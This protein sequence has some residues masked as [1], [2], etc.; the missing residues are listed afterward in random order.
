MN[1]VVKK[2]VTKKNKEPKATQSQKV[3]NPDKSKPASDSDQNIDKD[4]SP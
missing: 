1:K 4:P 2:E 3:D